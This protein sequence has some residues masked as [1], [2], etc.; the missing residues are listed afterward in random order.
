MK[1]AFFEQFSILV[2]NKRYNQAFKIIGFVP[3]RHQV[4]ED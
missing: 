3:F 4:R 2:V 1:T